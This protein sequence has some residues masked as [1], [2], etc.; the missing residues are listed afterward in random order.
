MNKKNK[1]C[2][3]DKLIWNTSKTCQKCFGIKHSKRMNGI[4][5]PMF[6]KKRPDSSKRMKG[7][8]N[9]AKRPEIRIKLIQNHIN[10]LGKNNP[11]YIHGKG[12]EPYPLEFNDKLKNK[13]RKRDNYECQNCGMTEEEHLIVYSRILTIHHIDYDKNN[14]EDTNLISICDGCNARANFNRNYWKEFYQNK[15]KED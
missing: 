4:N 2:K 15:I 12:N 8:N 1:R 13:I 11:N 14:C 6:G 3:C 10:V 5:N 7:K 9:I